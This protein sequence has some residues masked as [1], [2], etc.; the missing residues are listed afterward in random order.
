MDRI[1]DRILI[2]DTDQQQ[3]DLLRDFFVDAG[4]LCK[5]TQD[6]QVAFDLLGSTSFDFVVISD[7]IRGISALDFVKKILSFSPDI[8]V[9][10]I[11]ENAQL[12]S[13]IRGVIKRF[14]RLSSPVVLADLARLV[15]L[16]SRNNEAG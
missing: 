5:S 10:Y 3:A 14:R 6:T 2:V 12:T 8:F 7:R 16:N 1:S 9:I 13:E 4:V 11:S 15:R